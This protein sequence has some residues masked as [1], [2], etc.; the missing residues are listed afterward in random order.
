MGRFAAF[1]AD[2]AATE[3]TGRRSAVIVIE[4]YARRIATAEVSDR[5]GRIVHGTIAAY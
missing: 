1:L 2:M 3:P 4:P 5:L